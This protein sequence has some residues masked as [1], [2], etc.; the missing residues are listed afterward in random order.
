MEWG[1]VTMG[2]RIRSSLHWSLL[3]SILPFLTYAVNMTEV[4]VNNLKIGSCPVRSLCK[5]RVFSKKI[6]R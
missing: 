6:D 5:E 3:R 4:I 2:F 1:K